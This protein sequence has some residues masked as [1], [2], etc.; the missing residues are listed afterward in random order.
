MIMYFCSHLG[1]TQA[2]AGD[3]L[4]MMVVVVAPG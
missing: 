2:T 4:I 3:G 1:G